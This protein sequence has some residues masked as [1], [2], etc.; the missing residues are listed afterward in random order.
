MG[1][2]QA[3]TVQTSMI[4]PI[5]SYF[6]FYFLSVRVVKTFFLKVLPELT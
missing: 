3:N 4:E 2:W 6:I 1:V 5:K